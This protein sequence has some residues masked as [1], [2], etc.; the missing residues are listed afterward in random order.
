MSWHARRGT[1]ADGTSRDHTDECAGSLGLGA[2]AHRYRSG[3]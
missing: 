2:G 3:S 1:Y